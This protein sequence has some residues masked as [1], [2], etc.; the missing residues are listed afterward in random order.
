MMQ[1]GVGRA[2]RVQCDH[3]SAKSLTRDVDAAAA[4]EAIFRTV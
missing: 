1:P 2:S 3:A 4:A